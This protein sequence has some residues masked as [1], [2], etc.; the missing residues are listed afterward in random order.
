MVENSLT[1]KTGE[2][3]N[4]QFEKAMGMHFLVLHTNFNPVIHSGF[5]ENLRNAVSGIRTCTGMQSTG[6][7][8]GYYK[9]LITRNTDN[10]LIQQEIKNELETYFIQF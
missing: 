1:T 3:I 9:F 8:K 7:N 6:K 4:L 2:T 5:A 10:N